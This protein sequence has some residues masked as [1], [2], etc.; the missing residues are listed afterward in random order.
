MKLPSFISTSYKKSPAVISF[1]LI[2]LL[3][4]GPVVTL[5]PETIQA[6]QVAAA[7][8]E[9]CSND[10]AAPTEI[11]ESE[12]DFQLSEEEIAQGGAD[13][14]PETD[15]GLYAFLTEN[16]LT[17]WKPT[18]INLEDR[19]AL[20]RTMPGY[21]SQ[22][23]GACL[24]AEV[25]GDF[26]SLI[27]LHNDTRDYLDALALYGPR[28]IFN[29][30]I[31]RYAIEGEPCQL[32]NGTVCDE[33]TE[34]VTVKDVAGNDVKEKRPKYYDDTVWPNGKWD[35]P[36]ADVRILKSLIYLVTPESQGGAGHE[37]IAVGR[38]IQDNKSSNEF[39]SDEEDDKVV[40]PACGSGVYSIH[41][42][43]SSNPTNPGCVAQAF[44]IAEIDNIRMTTKITQKRRVG[45][46]KVSYSYK[47]FPIKVA[48]QTD[49]GID[50]SGGLPPVNVF[51][52]AKISFNG[53]MLDLL[54]E[55]GLGSELDASKL[56]I[57]NLG[58]MA[59]A[60]GMSVLSQIL[61]SPSGSLSGWDLPSTLESFGRIYIANQLG[62]APEAFA[63]K[64]GDIIEN[65]G[66][67]TLEKNMGLPSGALDGG[68]SEE[69]Y[70]NLGRRY[71][72]ETV[73]GIANNSLSGT[74][75][76]E[77][78]FLIKVGQGKIA[79]AYGLNLSDIQGKNSAEELK[80]SSI[81]AG[82]IF[83]SNSSQSV[84]EKLR[85]TFI[86]NPTGSQR[87]T[88]GFQASDYEQPTNRLLNGS[89]SLKDYFK[90]VG[91]RTITST[92]GAFNS[93]PANTNTREAVNNPLAG[94]NEACGG[95]LSQFA[96]SNPLGS[97]NPNNIVS[98]LTL[99]RP[100]LQASGAFSD[101]DIQSLFSQ[102]Q[103]A[104]PL[105]A[106]GDGGQNNINSQ[107]QAAYNKT[108]DLHDVVSSY[109]RRLQKV[110]T[111]N[112]SGG[113]YGKL[114]S[115]TESLSIIRGIESQL[116]TFQSAALS[117]LRQQGQSGRSAALN[118]SGTTLRFDDNQKL[119]NVVITDQDP[120]NAILSGDPA[121]FGI[122]GRSIAA[123]KLTDN[124][125][126][127]S[128]LSSQ[129]FKDLSPTFASIGKFGLT[130]EELAQKGLLPDD[131][132]RIFQKDLGSEVFKRIGE[133]ELLRVAWNKSEIASSVNESFTGSEVQDLIKTVQNVNSSINF[134]KDRYAK[135][136]DISSSM[137]GILSQVPQNSEVAALQQDF[138]KSAEEKVDTTPK[139]IL[140]Q[141][142][143]LETFFSRAKQINSNNS[144]SVQVKQK[145]EEGLF[146]VR[147]MIAGRELTFNQDVSGSSE[148]GGRNGSNQTKGCIS[149]TAIRNLAKDSASSASTA[150]AKK[151]SQEKFKSIAQSVAGCQLDTSLKIPAGS[152]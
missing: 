70:A 119:A 44:D 37:R 151:N 140:N 69:V 50:K 38:I 80:K 130:E 91:G 120:L 5:I 100:V 34:E 52:A 63:K 64:D 9:P 27:P 81:K 72:E 128:L 141:I 71:I 137:Q 67:A 26:F 42:Y 76:S 74:K 43:D 78:E 40:R 25:A 16:D 1:F 58:D 146:V 112:R 49:E 92:I 55:F 95:V 102:A 131:L 46:N 142:K 152:F 62:L 143:K 122:V 41:Y 99:K 68:N 148:S 45:G 86:A 132:Q 104:Q 93:K 124:A 110:D 118:L 17:S 94:G 83:S 28:I 125:V 66:R 15:E 22:K 35:A 60:I 116:E 14:S 51:E 61:N 97:C 105:F 134:Y 115:V 127:Q 30:P 6:A 57:T 2:E 33:T 109:I 20:L 10:L 36:K 47:E 54:E 98:T 29:N 85:L 75:T 114:A 123:Q 89:L 73:L 59:G 96:D 65:I 101:A 79:K 53:N 113:S 136:Q 39:E 126:N 111:S 19:L 24:K 23:K 18:L 117:Y 13:G 77:E 82:L 8:S 56:D 108:V 107:V 147:E 21:D 150:E 149:L 106:I 88:Y 4:L 135:L 12:S 48:W 138:K 121:T 133:N 90:M 103:N 84:D 139:G 144:I 3:I 87:D 11:S 31:D 129:L 145:T 32:W 7:S